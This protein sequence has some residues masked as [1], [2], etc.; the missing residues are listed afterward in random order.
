MAGLNGLQN[1]EEHVD[2]LL[3]RDVDVVNHFVRSSL[4]FKKKF[5]EI[6]EFDQGERIKLNFAHTFG[7]SIEVVT[8]YA[9]PHGTAVAIGM[10]MA[11]RISGQRGYLSEEIIKRC[12]TVLLKVIDIHVEL[13]EQPFEKYLKALKKDKKQVDN[14]LTSV[15]ITNYGEESE[16]SIVHDTT[17]SEIKDAVNYFI[18]LYKLRN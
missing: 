17:E 9:I 3:A 7:H 2:E 10:I 1:M 5:I 16:L 15:L 18:Q 4:Q 11:N 13:L 12:E 6:D 8:D 14:S